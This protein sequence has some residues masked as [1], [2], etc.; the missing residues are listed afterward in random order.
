MVEQVGRDDDVS[1][2]EE[3]LSG[4]HEVP[5]AVVPELIEVT[6]VTG[7]RR[8][9]AILCAGPGAAHES[10][11]LSLLAQQGNTYWCSKASD[12]DR[13]RIERA[14][15]WYGR[16]V[17]AVDYATMLLHGWM[18]IVPL[19]IGRKEHSDLML[20]RLRQLAECH[21]HTPGRQLLGW[22]AGGTE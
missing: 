1:W 17:S 6:C 21:G 12:E 11:G 3:G 16:S 20:Q 8:H 2:Q 13:V 5:Q 9:R 18:A 15:T 14:T 19:V 10:P 7:P 22:I 4:D